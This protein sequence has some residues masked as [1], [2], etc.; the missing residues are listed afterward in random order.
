VR[1]L[2]VHAGEES[3]RY[4]ALFRTA[5]PE[6]ETRVWPATGDATAIE[7]VACWNPP[8]GC[9]APLVNL[10]AVFALGAGVDRLLARPDLPAS[11]ALIRLT[12]AGMAEQMVE[13]ALL[14]VLAWQRGLARYAQQQARA[15]WQQH[16]PRLRSET[17]VGVLGLGEM[18]GAVA[19]A[20]AVLGY[21]VAA[22]SRTARVL[23]GVRV[24]AGN[25]GLEALLAQ[26][27]V[28][29]NMLPSTAATRALL[30]AERLA[31]LPQGGFVVNASRGD[32]L[33]ADALAAL[34][35]SGH[36]SGA[37]LD[38]F[39]T[40]PLPAASP[41]WRHPKIMIT[42]HVAAITLPDQ[43]VAQIAAKWRAFV[44]GETVAGLVDRT[45]GY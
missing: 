25:V 17:R 15:E 11:V 24:H 30:D 44:A 14:G 33:D 45:R 18:G 31:K 29:V 12:D 26:S 8:S 35:D 22:W 10:R 13:Y 39:A 28:L 23:T 1:A 40:E 16:P 27:D 37:L 3:A 41:L 6:L 43:T 36:L 7:Y 20:L 42:P 21:R 32:Q 9:F 34:L 38:V 4:G 19:S 5:L 2:L